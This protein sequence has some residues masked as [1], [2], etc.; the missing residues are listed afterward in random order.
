MD[1]IP[2]IDDPAAY[3]RHRLRKVLAIA[4]ANERYAAPTLFADLPLALHP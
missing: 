4:R 3:E 1:S 2:V